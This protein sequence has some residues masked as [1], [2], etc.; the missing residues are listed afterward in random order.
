MVHPSVET[1]IKQAKTVII[2]CIRTLENSQMFQATKQMGNQEEGHLN[3]IREL[4]GILT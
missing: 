3:T 1:P 4:C 2:N